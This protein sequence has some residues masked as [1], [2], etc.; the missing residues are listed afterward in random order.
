[1]HSAGTAEIA[2]ESG[3]DS[4]AVDDASALENTLARIRQR[5]ALH[6]HL[7]E[8]VAPGQERNIE[9]DLAAAAQG[10]YPG[11]EVR[12]RRVYLTPDAR[13]PAEAAAQPPQNAQGTTVKRRPAVNEPV[14]PPGANPSVG[15]PSPTTPAPPPEANQAPSEGGWRRVK[16]GEQP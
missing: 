12:Y 2:R 9:V 3:G 10:R 13:V 1:M 16:P 7:P 8:G 11:A 4:V 5:Y 15:T 6:F 14:G